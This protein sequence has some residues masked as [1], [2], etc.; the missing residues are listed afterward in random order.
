MVGQW[1]CI[2]DR[3]GQHGDQLYPY[4]TFVPYEIW[5]GPYLYPSFLSDHRASRRHRDCSRSVSPFTLL[6]GCQTLRNI[7]E[8]KLCIPNEFDA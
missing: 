7:P 8:G 5:P 1:G 2:G 4:R 6:L 3:A